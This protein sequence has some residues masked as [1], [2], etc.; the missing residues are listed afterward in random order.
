M[1][2]LC[3]A[4]GYV[5]VRL[6]ER[7]VHEELERRGASIAQL[8]AHKS[9]PYILCG[10]SEALDFIVRSAIQDEDV[11]YVVISDSDGNPIASTVPGED[12]SETG[13]AALDRTAGAPSP[14]EGGGAE[15]IDV[16][17]PITPDMACAWSFASGAL[18]PEILPEHVGTVRVGLSTTREGTAVA[19][20]SRQLAPLILVS[21]LLSI[22][23]TLLVERKI[24][25]PVA[26]LVRATKAIASGDLS[27]RVD[28]RSND[29]FGE[30]A[31][32]FN[33]MA[34][35]LST[36]LEKI[37][38]YSHSLEDKVRLRTAELEAKTRALQKANSELQEL[39]RLKSGFVSNVSHE[40]RTPLTS[41]RAIA[42]I[43][44]KQD[45]SLPRERTFEFLRIIESQTDR[46]TKLIG[47]ILD[48]SRLEHGGPVPELQPV[49]LGSAVSEALNSV[50]GIAE[51]RGV[52]LRSAV[53]RDLPHALAQAGKVEQVL[54][55]L[56]GNALKFTPRGGSVSI[57]ALH[58]VEESI[59]RN[60][61]IPVSGIVISVTDTGTG[62]PKEQLKAVFDK[63]RQIENAAWGKPSGSGLGLSIS[64]EIV[65][66]FGGTIWAESELGE[67][68]AFHFTI[69]PAEASDCETGSPAEAGRSA[70][71]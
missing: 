27:L 38:S 54:V 7:N 39:D 52:E 71:A 60:S 64:K 32:S 46:L 45:Q 44:G 61:P 42:E 3:L 1:M 40:L 69:R 35:A 48:L 5:F 30:L 16:A 50:R 8:L 18:R 56:L 63:F 51:D 62:I 19:M 49:S 20:V 59:W 66:R 53:P 6:T 26:E 2:Y 34:D 4:L 25:R 70:A 24:T 36:T 13:G 28:V 37:E 43:L 68:S 67:G 65:E 9:C 33:Q 22:V 10:D 14:G 21:C 31:K 17:T 11:R 12:I 57:E 29:E 23:G 55:N 41:I 58:L 15:I 47:D